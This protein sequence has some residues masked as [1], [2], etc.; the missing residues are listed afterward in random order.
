MD[1]LNGLDLYGN[2]HY[3]RQQCDC[4]EIGRRK[5]LKIPRRKSC[6]FDSGQSHQ[7]LTIK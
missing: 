6:R 5:G 7:L 1:P 3:T 2:R 4:G